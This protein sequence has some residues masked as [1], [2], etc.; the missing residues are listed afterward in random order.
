MRLARLLVR[1]CMPGRPYAA[2][3]LPVIMVLVFTILVGPLRAD[4]IPNEPSNDEAA[5]Q[6]RLVGVLAS[7]GVPTLQA[8]AVV[9][10]LDPHE[11]AF[12]NEHPG[13][14]TH[15][16]GTGTTILT[17]VLVGAV[18]VGGVAAAIHIRNKDNDDDPP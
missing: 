1:A 12:F 8:R 14:A 15:V 13:S 16:T 10:E 7:N 2:T 5:A 9:S 11:V 17:F 3:K 18:I 4:V 6:E